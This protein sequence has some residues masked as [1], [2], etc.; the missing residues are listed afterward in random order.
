MSLQENLHIVDCT[1]FQ[2]DNELFGPRPPY[3]GH[4]DG[5]QLNNFLVT[6]SGGRCIVFMDEFE[7]TSREI[8]NTL[9]LPFEHGMLA[10]PPPKQKEI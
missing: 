9:L 1:T 3:T 4:E 2:Q 5:S 8:H 10:P 6:R 7:K